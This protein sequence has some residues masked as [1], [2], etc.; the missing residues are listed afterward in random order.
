M[1]APAQRSTRRSL[2]LLA[3]LAAA[4]LVLLLVGRRSHDNFVATLRGFT[5]QVVRDHQESVGDWKT[6]SV[7]ANFVLGDALRTGSHSTAALELASSHQLSLEADTLV[8]F[9]SRP[10]DPKRARVALEMG[11]VTLDAASDAFELETELGT[12]RIEAHGRARLAKNGDARRLQVTIGAAEIDR[13]G[14]HLELRVGDAVEISEK[15]AL[16]RVPAAPASA[17]AAPAISASAVALGPEG[18]ASAAIPSALA[19][20]GRAF[21]RGLERV[22][23][24]ITVGESIVIHDPR[25]PTAVGVIAGERCTGSALLSVDGRRARA[26]E[27]VGEGRIGVALASGAHHYVVHCLGEGGARGDKI[28]QGTISI[29]PDSGVRRL[30]SSAPL[31]NV[32]ADGRRY[33]VLYQ[34]L[35]P[36]IAIQWP[37]APPASSYALTISSPHGT[38]TVATSSPRYFFA[39]GALGEGQHSFSFQG[40]GRSSRNTTVVI[41]FDNAAPAASIASPADGS[42]APGS[43]VL[44][45]GTA[46]PGSV[47][48]VGSTT[49]QQDDQN[50]FST[51][52]SAPPDQALAIRFTQ[53]QRGV[54]YYLRR[55]AL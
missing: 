11:E 50:R 25:P 20:P 19:G 8:R 30:A 44:V 23:L 3:A 5:G 54:H 42:F 43:S 27:R 18:A 41:R 53:P 21:E 22:D 4:A 55:S 16:N 33:T 37:N 31:T 28:G 45:S 14:Q 26:E 13:D 49:L 48:T 9:L 46:Q 39:S 34:S 32:D 29:I 17:S 10:S 6:A 15:G 36:R 47:V 2:R 1:T 35:Q 12:V 40:A 7:G 52:V 38:K 51:A 24:S